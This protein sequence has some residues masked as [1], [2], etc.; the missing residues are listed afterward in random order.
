M[1]DLPKIKH[2]S[3][4]NPSSRLAEELGIGEEKR[5]LG[6]PGPVWSVV[7]VLLGA[8][9][10]V[11][12][13]TYAPAVP[14]VS[15][16]ASIFG[17]L[18]VWVGFGS[19]WLLGLGAWV[20]GVGLMWIGTYRLMNKGRLPVR[21][22]LGWI[23]LLVSVVLMSGVQDTLGVAIVAEYGIKG[24][25]GI[26]G[27]YLSFEG[28]RVFLGVLGTFLLFGFVY[29][30]SF[31]WAFGFT[32]WDVYQRVSQDIR[33]WRRR[34]RETAAWSVD[35]V[36]KSEGEKTL[37]E[38]LRDE[39]RFAERQERKKQEELVIDSKGQ[40][41]M[42]LPVKEE[43]TIIDGSRS[44]FAATPSTHEP[45]KRE[46]PLISGEYDDY[47]LPNLDILRLPEVDE[48]KNL[49]DRSALLETQAKIVETLRSFKVPVTPGNITKGPSIT[50]YEV[51]PE[52]GLRVSMIKKAGPD[53]ARATKAER[54]N[55]LAPIPGKDTV[56]IEIANVK[57]VPVHLRELLQ[58][59]EFQGS[60][61]R[62][63]L[64]IG[65]DVYG[66][67]VV[68]DLAKMPHL[69]IAGATNSG[70]SVC[71][72]SLI[73]SMLYKFTPDDLKLVLIDPKVVE[74]KLY[75]TL[76]HLMVPVVTEP[77]KVIKALSVA[78][79]EMEYRYRVFAQKG[80]RNFESYNKRQ[81]EEEYRHARQQGIRL[82]GDPNFSEGA[83]DSDLFGSEDEDDELIPENE[84]ES[85]HQVPSPALPGVHHE[86]E[87][88][89]PK[90]F[91]YIVIIIDEMA[92]LMHTVSKDMEHYIARLTAKARAAG[93]H[94][95]IATQTPRKDVVTG[96]IKANIPSRIA[97]SVSSS[98]DSRIILDA[99]GAENLVGKGD[100]LFL[101]PGTAK[102][103]RTQGALVEDEDVEAVVEYCAR[104]KQQFDERAQAD[105]E[106]PDDGDGDDDYGDDDYGDGDSKSDEALIARAVEVV[107][108]EQKAS[109]S[110][111]QRRLSVGFNKASV[112]IDI[113]EDRGY[114]GPAP[115]A[116]SKPREVYLD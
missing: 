16:G 25:G 87:D 112:L 76:P 111:L 9:L 20:I 70:K 110:L 17:V 72:N 15:E 52:V 36:G 82:P 11:T 89:L 78:I 85:Q 64:A 49:L 32:P 14:G 48:S 101:S 50:R 53:I 60:K 108:Q 83:S 65:K 68:S 100:L 92:D 13:G 63:P 73:V 33:A 30:L 10:L 113:L 27:Y 5:V 58:S 26:V 34:R 3:T 77:K 109:A 43:P 24:L 98:T 66:N 102:L 104:W 7:W 12:L 23:G 71:I 62:I 99:G 114:I 97:L 93:I 54:I 88:D 96:V 103:E 67:V 22:W 61:H 45:K 47:V 59:E 79:N 8:L 1:E 57:K 40:I 18:G 115:T 6:L 107:R 56:G 19:Y 84:A 44:N 46:K 28:C 31:V 90:K 35:Q 39:K 41:E 75:E 91:P 116:S 42:N 81:L 86:D 2:R 38:R 37:A 80:V 55:I 94:L 74:L 4:R 69:L 95:I 106:S 21:V 51:Y 29:I 105:I